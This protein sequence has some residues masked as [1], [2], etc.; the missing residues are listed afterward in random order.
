MHFFNCLSISVMNSC[1]QEAK[2]HSEY[3]AVW[4]FRTE[5]RFK[6]RMSGFFACYVDWSYSLSCSASLYLCLTVVPIDS[7]NETSDYIEL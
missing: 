7:W 6:F 1:Q 2:L 5:N 3:E 4:L